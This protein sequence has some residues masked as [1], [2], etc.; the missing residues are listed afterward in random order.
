[1]VLEVSWVQL[2]MKLSNWDARRFS[3][4]NGI[5]KIMFEKTQR[6]LS[7]MLHNWKN[8]RCKYNREKESFVFFFL[9]FFTEITNIFFENILIVYPFSY[10]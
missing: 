8:K 6:D 7:D 2:A 3:K 10:Y 1:M 9:F 4:N 5:D